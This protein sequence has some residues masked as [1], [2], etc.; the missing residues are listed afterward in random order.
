MHFNKQQ[1]G[2]LGDLSARIFGSSSRWQKIHD[3]GQIFDKMV[4]DPKGK[5]YH[6]IPHYK[7][8]IK[9]GKSVKTLKSTTRVSE[10]TAKNLN[11]IKE[12]SDKK[13]QRAVYRKM[14]FGELFQYLMML[15]DSRVVGHISSKRPED[16]PYLLAC[17]L[18]EGELNY[19]F[20]LRHLNYEDTDLTGNFEKIVYEFPEK[21]KEV[22][23]K[24]LLSKEDSEIAAKISESYD[25]TRFVEL[26]RDRLA[27]TES[28]ECGP[29]GERYINCIHEVE[30][31]VRADKKEK[32]VENHKLERME[33]KEGKSEE[34]P[35]TTG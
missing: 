28:G 4:D 1:R 6:N 24:S 15:W 29:V 14:D 27:E 18:V 5:V 22:V 19:G 25:A 23:I 30:E 20:K 7:H 33:N 35:N 11:L 16:M 2:M 31:V 10:V 34:Q 9:D 13:P 21:V 12:F 26:V 8:E 32:H 17:R 3:K